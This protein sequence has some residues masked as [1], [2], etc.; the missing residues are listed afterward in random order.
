MKLTRPP[1]YLALLLLT[2]C[3]SCKESD[4][5]PAPLPELP[6]AT[7]T[8]AR[9]FGCLVNG[10]PFVAKGINLV[11]GEWLS[12]TDWVVSAGAR[13]QNDKFNVYMILTDSLLPVAKPYPLRS[14]SSNYPTSKLVGFT[15]N[16]NTE[17]CDYKG[18]RIRTGTLTITRFDAVARIMAGSFAFTLYEPG[19]DS[20]RV[21]D[22]RFDV[23]F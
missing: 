10:K 1:L 5:A 19:C 3:S 21:T 16:A 13:S 14:V 20:L 2:Q 8:G 15:T 18:T 22:G 4:P 17:Q 23:Q 6:P 9:T 11:R 12:N 7:Q